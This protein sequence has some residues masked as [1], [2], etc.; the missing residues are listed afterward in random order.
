ME[1][2]GEFVCWYWG[3]KVFDLAPRVSFLAS[4][5]R[6]NF[7]KKLQ[8]EA[9]LD[10]RRKMQGKNQREKMKRKSSGSIPIPFNI[11]WMSVHYSPLYINCRIDKGIN[12]LIPTLT[13]PLGYP[14]R[15]NTLNCFFS[16]FVSC[17]FYF[18]F[19]N[20]SIFLLHAWFHEGKD[21]S[22]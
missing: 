10:Y 5:W 9:V 12:C 11:E 6:E 8:K 14:P 15:T 16:L 18:F 1:S 17:R 22:T 4:P 7:L 19:R 2:A 21:W 13:S 3:L 20:L